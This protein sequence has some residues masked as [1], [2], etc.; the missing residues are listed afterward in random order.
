MI[1]HVTCDLLDRSARSSALNELLRTS[2]PVNHL[3]FLQRYRGQDDAWAGEIETTLTATKE[4]IE[5]LRDSFASE[6]ERSIVLVSSVIGDAVVENQPV[7]Y[8][9]AKV[10]LN[11]MVRYYAVT[12]GPLGIRVNG[13]APCTMMKEESRHYYEG[14]AD[15]MQMFR[16]ISPLGR[17]GTSEDVAGVVS[18]LTSAQASFVTGQVLTVDGGTSLVWQEWLARK[19]TPGLS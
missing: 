2:G 13:I 3:V 10:G 15:L 14:N 17:I 6:G 7:G 19:L 18:F 5:A 1:H 11:A 4:V 9:V 12:L 8:H 16:T